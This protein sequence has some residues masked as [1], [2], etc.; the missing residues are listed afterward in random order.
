MK[1]SVIN[2]ISFNRAIILILTSSIEC[3]GGYEILKVKI[4]VVGLGS[5]GS[6]ITTNLL[7]QQ[8]YEVHV[9]NRTIEKAKPFEQKGATIHKTSKELASAVDI[10][11]TSLTDDKA[12][13]EVAFGKQ[14]FL[15]A[16][17]ENAVW[18]E[19]STIDPDASIKFSEESKKLGKKKLEV[20]IVGNPEMMVEHKVTLL[21]GG[22]KN[23]FEQQEVFLKAL[24]NAVL[25]IGAVGTGLKMKL[26]INLYL[27]L[28]VETFSEAYVFSR[29]LGFGPDDFVNV[30]NKT[31][32]KNYVSEVKGPKIAK[33]DFAPSFT[34][35]NL[36]KDLNLA[37]AQSVK[38]K[39][40]L[41]TMKL[42]IGKFSDAVSAGEGK[43]DFSAIARQIERSNGLTTD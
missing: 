32:H 39:A 11:I 31:A 30:I 25:Y 23:L 26:A 15:D 3:L 2:H 20:P 19:M 33:S 21:I 4:G 5:M 36:F 6:A 18:L 38:N 13:Y 27:G 8:K 12:V 28:N 9:Y 42:V 40:N 16:L 29:K 17:Q 35:N 34:M 7:A 43:Q 37:E 10:L 22:D 41:P 1:S 14:G 24:G